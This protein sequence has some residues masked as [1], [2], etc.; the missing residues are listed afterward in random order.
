MWQAGQGGSACDANWVKAASYGYD[1]FGNRQDET[2][3]SG[4]ST[5]T[6][7]DSLF[8]SY[9]LAVS[10]QPASGLGGAT[11]TT[12]ITRYGINATAGGSGLVGQVQSE[13]DANEAVT[14]YTYDTF[15]RLTEVRKP[16][17]GFSNP[18][19]EKI[20]Y[21][22]DQGLYVQRHLLRDDGNG[23]ARCECDLPGGAHVLR[24]V[25]ACAAGAEGVQ[26]RPV[27]PG[28]PALRWAGQ[29]GSQ[30]GA[31]HEY[32]ERSDVPGGELEWAGRD[33]VNVRSAGTGDAGHA[34]GRQQD[35]HVLPES[36]DRGDS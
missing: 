17:A 36:A 14:F 20:V 13:T 4:Q 33:A 3:A 5:T 22:T 11:L 25:G 32:G 34:G 23:D 12:T 21:T 1:S 7:Y 8:H 9:P 24:W 30:F 26:Q 15:G 10:V 6:T 28:E 16:G 27:E 35:L 29:P 2:T 19:T 18:A 31:V